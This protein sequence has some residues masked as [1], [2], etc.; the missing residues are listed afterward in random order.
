MKKILF[1]ITVAL[2]IPMVSICQ[3]QLDNLLIKL[4]KL[5]KENRLMFVGK[6]QEIYLN[7]T[8][9][10]IDMDN[11]TIPLGSY[12]VNYL[13]SNENIDNKYHKKNLDI[14]SFRCTE[15]NCLYRQSTNTY[16]NGFWIYFKSKKACYDFIN[17][18]DEIKN[19]LIN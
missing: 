8:N 3:V 11:L 19:I 14:V 12:T 1:I 18:L 17:T 13:N 16:H 6:V 7:K 4:N 2:I 5:Q 9:K 10:T 15:G